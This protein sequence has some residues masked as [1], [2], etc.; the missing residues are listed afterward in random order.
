ME[1]QINLYMENKKIILIMIGLPGSGKS[2]FARHVKYDGLPKYILSQDDYLYDGFGVYKWSPQSV[3]KS[4][5]WNFDRFTKAV[6]DESDKVI[7][8]DNTN[9]KKSYIKK[10]AE[11]GIKHGYQVYLIFMEEDDKK[12]LMKRGTHNV[13]ESTMDKMITNFR[14]LFIKFFFFIEKKR[15]PGAFFITQEGLDSSVKSLSNDELMEFLCES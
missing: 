1:I 7:I 10:Y 5:K 3:Q 4:V 6:E 12:V 11:L 14:E 2:T 15:G 9:L 8:V 13:P